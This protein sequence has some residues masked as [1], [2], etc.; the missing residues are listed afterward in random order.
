MI[1]VDRLPQIELCLAMAYI[2]VL[3]DI[4]PPPCCP[5]GNFLSGKLALLPRVWEA[6]EVFIRD[7]CAVGK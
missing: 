2:S 4:V 3:A 7:I 1:T 6:E 5:P